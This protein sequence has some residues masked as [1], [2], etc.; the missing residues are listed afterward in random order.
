MA[1]KFGPKWLFG[2]A[3]LIPAVLTLLT[4]LVASFSAD[5]LFA[6]RFVQGLAQGVVF[7][8]QMVLL[9]RYRLKRQWMMLVELGTFGIF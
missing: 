4:P 8:S 5:L 6:L 2:G 7:P 3:V 1:E 9:A